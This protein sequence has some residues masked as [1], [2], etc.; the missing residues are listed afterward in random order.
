MC[1]FVLKAEDKGLELKFSPHSKFLLNLRPFKF[2]KNLL[3]R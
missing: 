3:I 2:L 1:I